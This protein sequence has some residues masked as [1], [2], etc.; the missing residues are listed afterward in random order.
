MDSCGYNLTGSGFLPGDLNLSDLDT[1]RAGFAPLL[2]TA[3][4]T[5]Q[6]I[7]YSDCDPQGIVFNGNY[8]R[9]WD[10]AATDWLD[11]AGF[12]FAGLEELGVDVVTARLEM[13]FRSPATMGDTLSTTVE[14]EQFGITSMMLKVETKRQSD[15]RIIADGRLVWVFVDPGAK[16]SVPVP[17]KVKQ[18]LG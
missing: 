16:K 7:R 9:Y 13:D 15:D 11:D 18:R 17:D 3:V 12:G 14:V 8:A 10:D 1:R 4:A 5:T 6:R 2:F